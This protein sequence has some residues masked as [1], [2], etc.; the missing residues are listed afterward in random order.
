MG[1]CPLNKTVEIIDGKWTVLILWHLRDRPLRFSQLHKKI[2]DATQKMLTQQLRHL[3]RHQLIQR[4]VYPEVPPKVEYSLTE[5]GE[6][7][8]PILLSLNEWGWSYYKS[9]SSSSEKLN[10]NK[11]E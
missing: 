7:L 10:G 1:F 9:I 8:K 6:S 4:K 11:G 2:P 5:Y 3:E